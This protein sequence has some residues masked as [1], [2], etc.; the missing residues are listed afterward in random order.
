LEAFN[1]FH[2]SLTHSNGLTIG[3]TGGLVV[4]G[5]PVQ[6]AGCWFDFYELPSCRFFPSLILLA[7]HSNGIFRL[8]GISLALPFS[9]LG[10]Y[11]EP[12]PPLL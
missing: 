9:V 3:L 6:S 10:I 8:P 5:H 12:K 1:R 2:F 11:S 4:G 7:M